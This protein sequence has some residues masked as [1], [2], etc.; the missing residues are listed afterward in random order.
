[1]YQV[2][3]GFAYLRGVFC[4]SIGPL[5]IMTVSNNIFLILLSIKQTRVML[6][7]MVFATYHQT[8]LTYTY[9]IGVRNKQNKEFKRNNR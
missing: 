9:V 6:T 1:M 2:S 5:T 3:L 8:P 4:T 7:K